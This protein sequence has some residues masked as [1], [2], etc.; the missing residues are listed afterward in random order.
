MPQQE[1]SP[2][3]LS[4]AEYRRAMATSSYQHAVSTDSLVYKVLLCLH[5]LLNLAGR[6]FLPFHRLGNWIYSPR[7]H[8]FGDLGGGIDAMIIHHSPPGLMMNVRTPSSI[9]QTLARVFR[10][11]MLDLASPQDSHIWMRAGP[12]RHIP[13]HLQDSSIEKGVVVEFPSPILSG[14]A[15]SVS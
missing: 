2:V 8:N 7:A 5:K 12:G 14:F 13:T 11:I 1:R 9:Q 10:H 6:L 15:T 3:S 4:A